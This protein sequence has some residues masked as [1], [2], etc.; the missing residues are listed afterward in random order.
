MLVLKHGPS[1]S[2]RAV[3]YARDGQ[4]ESPVEVPLE[5]DFATLHCEVDWHCV[6]FVL[7]IEVVRMREP[8][9][10]VQGRETNLPVDGG[11]SV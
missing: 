11:Q 3:R 8:E 9:R 7:Q 4:G 10:G 2:G 1:V 6:R 5:G